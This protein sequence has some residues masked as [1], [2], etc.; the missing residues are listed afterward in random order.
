MSD[1]S[2]AVC[3]VVVL[4]AAAAAADAFAEL[5]GAVAELAVA[6]MK[7]AYSSGHTVCAGS[8]CKR[9]A[10]KDG[11]PSPASHAQ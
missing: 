11:M 5:K 4:A 7:A 8:I 1:E 6:L 10:K 3:V 2:S 9:A